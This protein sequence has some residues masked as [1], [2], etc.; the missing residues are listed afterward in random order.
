[1]GDGVAVLRALDDEPLHVAAVRAGGTDVEGVRRAAVVAAE[2]RQVHL[3]VVDAAD[4]DDARQSHRDEVP[5]AVLPIDAGLVEGRA[6]LR[7]EHVEDVLVVLDLDRRV[8]L[9][10]AA[11]VLGLA[12]ERVGAD[13]G[14][15]VIHLQSRDTAL[16]DVGDLRVVP[17]ANVPAAHVP[18]VE[19][20]AGRLRGRH[21]GADDA[22]G[23]GAAGG[24][25]GGVGGGGLKSEGHG[26]TP[27]VPRRSRPTPS[28][29]QYFTHFH[30]YCQTIRVTI[31]EGLG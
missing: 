9:A 31:E 29:I 5:A 16:V 20:L 15:G 13:N 27:W 22:P 6:A 2:E 18:H 30:R 12:V 10:D 17:Q 4:A 26:R 8:L 7:A 11:H 1:M 28:H 19:G 24:E 23:V 25:A 21:V 14:T 3:V